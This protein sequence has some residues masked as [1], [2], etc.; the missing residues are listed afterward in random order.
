M[1]Q[2]ATL[3][4]PRSG[5]LIVVKRKGNPLQAGRQFALGLLPKPSASLLL[6]PAPKPVEP[7]ERAILF[8]ALAAALAPR[9]AGQLLIAPFQWADRQ[10]RKLAEQYEQEL[11]RRLKAA[12]LGI[13][14][15]KAQTPVVVE[16]IRSQDRAAERALNR[17]L[18]E[19]RIGETQARTG[20]IEQR[21]EQAA[22]RMPLEI[23]RDINQMLLTAGKPET[24]PELRQFILGQVQQLYREYGIE[25]PT[26]LPTQVSPSPAQQREEAAATRELAQAKESEAQAALTQERA[27][28]E[29][30]VRPLE[31][32][33][34]RAR[35]RLI[36]AQ[37]LTERMQPQLLQARI[38]EIRANIAQGWQNLRLRAQAL[39]Q[40]IQR[41]DW[42]EARGV[43]EAIGK[44]RAFWE[45]QVQELRRAL[46]VSVQQELYTPASDRQAPASRT[47]QRST[48]LP[49]LNRIPQNDPR[50]P[51]VQQLR[52]AEKLANFYRQ[53]EQLLNERL[54]QRRGI[55][56]QW[57]TL[58]D[59]TQVPVWEEEN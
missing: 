51:L 57:I 53:S 38:S 36:Q 6:P 2:F 19:A 37:E 18:I 14:Q 33:E 35:I 22:R 13:E 7:D 48:T 39:Q 31:L 9:A 30:Q 40:A 32:Q 4:R 24:P 3:R 16:Q 8:S 21:T 52:E 29:Q 15:Q 11:N 50:Y 1:Q 34:R 58:P 42:N 12:Q 55:R 47:V 26:P 20:E 10:N 25:T 41:Q 44:S 49:D 56:V 23:Q 46:G 17:P 45:R 27:I 59:G 54:L 43:V 28:T 5:D